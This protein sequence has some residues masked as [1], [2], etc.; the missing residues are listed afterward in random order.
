MSLMAAAS[1][2]FRITNFLMA[3]SLGTHRAQLVPRIGCT[4]PRPFLAR[5]LFLLFLVILEAPRR[6]SS[7]VFLICV[8]ASEKDKTG[9]NYD[10]VFTT[11]SPASRTVADTEMLSTNWMNCNRTEPLSWDIVSIR[12]RRCPLAWLYLL[13]AI[14]WLASLGW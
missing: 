9:Q 11:V 5:P 4:W 6:E 8:A 12:E 13:P 1:T 7:I 14:L 2:M 10:T 3:L